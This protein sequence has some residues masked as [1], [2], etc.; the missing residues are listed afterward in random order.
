MNPVKNNGLSRRELLKQSGKIAAASA[1]AGMV[2]PQVHA[3]ESNTISVALIGCGG[4][5]TGAAGNSMSVKTGPTKLVAMADVFPQ[6]LE[7]SFKTLKNEHTD[8]VEVSDDRKFIGFDGYKKAID[9]LKPG[10][11]AV[12]TTPPAFR[13]VQF[14]YAIEKGVN[15]FM[16]KPIAVDGP[17]ARRMF[18]LGEEAKKKN[19]KVA[20]GLMCR[21]CPA[22]GELF[23]R[24]KDGELGDLLLLRAYR[25]AGQTASE[26]S[27]SNATHK[28]GQMSDLLYQ[29][30]RFHS[31][32]WASGGCYSDFLIHNID[33]CCWMKDAWPINARAV[34]GRH[35][36]GDNVDQNFDVYSVEYTFAD[37]AKLLLEGRTIP[38]CAQQFSSFAHGTKHAA[39]VSW[40]GH[41]PTHACI[42][43][44]QN[45]TNKPADK[46]W[47]FPR[48]KEP[49]LYQLEWEHFT[50]A[51]RNNKP[52]S[53]VERSVEA[54]LVTAMGR[55][56]A[57]TG[58]IITRDQMLNCQHEF[59][60][61]ADK[62]TLESPAPLKSLS[63]G[64][65]PVPE[66]GRKKG[67]EWR[68][69]YDA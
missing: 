17:S 10:D 30:R 4:R 20:V 5:G 27:V 47:S 7:E 44:D 6:R 57:H 21:H 33:E 34:G 69:Y 12:L 13:W 45:I 26:A 60:P 9:C 52:Y 54:S 55:M 16:E 51:I 19:M 58:Q 65:Y 29:I 37:G 23:Q 25:M 11:V 31:F 28:Y 48:E 49:D 2:I 68:E 42:Y 22:R 14:T 24:I 63:N 41:F 66:P 64:K 40:S 35:Y 46:I 67:S 59:A 39:T 1:F 53:E 56:S 3:G 15:V 8:K 32:L 50:D 38:G 43:R 18:Q 61:N 36:R 62:L